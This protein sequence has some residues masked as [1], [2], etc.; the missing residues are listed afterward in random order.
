[1]Q[2]SQSQEAA[3]QD[4]LNFLDDPAAREFTISGPA[5]SGKTFLLTYLL[6]AA[7]NEQ[8]LL[9]SIDDTESSLAIYLS[10]TTHK[11]VEV[12]KQ[13]VPE[14]TAETVYSRLNLRVK[15]DFNTGTTSLTK[16]NYRN[17]NEFM[18]S[19]KFGCKTILVIDEASMVNREL[20][21]YIKKLLERTQTL[22]IVYVGDKYQLPPVME[23][24]SP[25]FTRVKNIS[26]LTE[27][28][29]QSG[30]ST[31]I[32]VAQEMR[33]VM[34]TAGLWPEI[35]DSANIKVFSE[36]QQWLQ[37]IGDAFTQN[38]DPMFN[39]V[40]AWSN[41]HVNGYNNHVLSALGHTTMF[42]KDNIAIN[43]TRCQPNPEV[44]FQADEPL[45]ICEVIGEYEHKVTLKNF[46]FLFSAMKL[47]VR[48][49]RTG[50]SAEIRVPTDFQQF[51]AVLKQMADAIKRNKLSWKPYFDLKERVC[52]LRPSF[53]Q[54]LHKSQGST[55]GNV[56][57]D[58][59]DVSRN[60]KWLEVAQLVYTGM[61]RASNNVYFYGELPE[62]WTK[63]RREC[64]N[65]VFT[66][67]TASFT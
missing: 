59:Q 47:R 49:L 60:N 22:R 50:N 27:I 61:T 36:P 57:I 41:K 13:A 26:Y 1:M 19:L 28:Q 63:H 54:T 44:A 53:A 3:K 43:N 4:F 16:V 67:E 35:V 64:I 11:A 21:D 52:D 18:D 38:P 42:Y 66:H 48:S 62:K 33:D 31:I 29:R 58:L 55:Y 51:N 10:A 24:C 15:N 12:L 32:P 2:L 8:Q 9:S 23:S 30:S 46:E 45:R 5:G 6:E 39:R 65:E 34:D 56:F 17:K 20:Y 7:Y 25:V 40:L 14:Y 37:A